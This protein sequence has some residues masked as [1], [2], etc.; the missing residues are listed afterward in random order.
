MTDDDLYDLF[1]PLAKVALKRMF[2]GIS[3]YVD[4][5]IIAIAI[6]GIV[7]MKADAETKS[8]FLSAGSS[9]FT[10]DAKGK[11]MTMN[12]F[13]LPDEA[14]E[15]PDALRPWFQLSVESARRSGA[16]KPK[17]PKPS[18]SPKFAKLPV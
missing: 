13:V 6:D 11:T 14:Y 17:T 7:Y 10:Y 8:A 12:Y 9:P 3:V 4:G 18:K 15:D 1:D 5:L 16:R 2:G